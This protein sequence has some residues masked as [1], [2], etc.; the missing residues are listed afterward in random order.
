MRTKDLNIGEEEQTKGIAEFKTSFPKY[1]L[2]EQ[3]V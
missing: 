3:D 2:H 1:I